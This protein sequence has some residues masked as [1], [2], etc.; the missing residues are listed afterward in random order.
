MC[1]KERADQREMGFAIEK[2]CVGAKRVVQQVEWQLKWQSAFGE[3]KRR[4]LTPFLA[5]IRVCQRSM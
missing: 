5:R 2:Q 3:G 4:S 1:G